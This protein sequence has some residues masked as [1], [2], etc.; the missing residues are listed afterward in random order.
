MEVDYPWII[1]GGA[2]GCL[3]SKYCSVSRVGNRG[4]RKVHV[5]EEEEEEED[6]GFFFTTS[7]IPGWVIY[8]GL[9]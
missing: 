9:P 2:M 3:W 1:R 7:Q 5:G 4:W 6:G 8:T